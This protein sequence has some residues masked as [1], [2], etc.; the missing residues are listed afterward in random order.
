MVLVTLAGGL[1]NQLFQFSAGYSLSRKRNSILILDCS[2]YYKK[3]LLDS[4]DLEYKNICQ[5]RLDK[6]VD[7]NDFIIVKNIYVSRL[8]RLYFISIHLFTFGYFR[9]SNIQEKKYFE[10]KAI[11]KSSNY[12]LNGYWQNLS[13]FRKD[14]NMILEKFKIKKVKKKK[15]ISIHI[16]R[17]DYINSQFDICDSKYFLQSL[18]LIRSKKRLKKKII[19]NFF[20]LDLKWLKSNLDLSNYNYKIINNKKDP[21]NDFFQMCNSDNIIISN[22]S[23]SWWAAAFIKYMNEDNIV[24]CPKFWGNKIYFKRI[25]IYP[26]T[27]L[28]I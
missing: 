18:N 1:G 24:I 28:K 27:W 22:S 26:D 11:P 23:Y 15:N 5:F 4:S 21:I 8:I 9:Y 12:F 7:I 13:Y 20:C 3:S 14:L 25:N 17:G 16:R 2:D 6:V 10:Y 19:Y